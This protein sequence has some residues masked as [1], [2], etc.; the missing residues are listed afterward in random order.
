M[1][2]H[3]TF[4][5]ISIAGLHINAI[6]KID[7]LAQL[8]TRIQSRQK[9]FVVT[10][11][12]EF[13]YASMRQPEVRQLL[14]S[15]DFAIPDGVGI[16]W[17]HLFLNQPLTWNY[18]YALII[19]A[20]LQVVWTGASILL[21]PSLV[22]KDIPEKIVGADFIWDLSK[23]AA[24][25]NFSVYLLGGWGKTTDIVAKKLQS[26]FPRLQIVGTSTKNPDDKSIIDDINAARPDMVFVAL[27]AITQ[28]QWIA[29]NLSKITASFAIGLGGTF[30]YIAG[31]K[32]QP[33][34][35]VR[36]SGLEWLYRLIT[37]PTRISRIFNA[38]FGLVT[39][40]VR[41][42]VYESLDYRPNG[43]AVV[44]NKDGKILLC[45]R[46][47][48]IEKTQPG[49]TFDNYW[50]FPQGG[51]DIGESIVEGTKRELMEETQITSIE[52]LA[53]A[54]Y[55]NMY[56]WNNAMRPLNTAKR[57]RFK[58]QSQ[59]TVFFTFTGDDSEIILDEREL[60]DWKWVH[61]KDVIKTI[62]PERREHAEA[63]LAELAQLTKL[64]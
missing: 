18:F 14:N 7:L 41:Y 63:V 13:L 2:Q 49:R 11:Y 56:S 62:A 20:W 10:P 50:Q 57:Y 37:Q 5:K 47:P 42:K 4:K 31:T 25:N 58:G 39:S 43:S 55:V 12:S 23:L 51:L 6:T 44:I 9:T 3:N 26:K 38:T 33:P 59:S 19:Q 64:A 54:K 35:F 16:L 30:D 27:G 40:L 1:E 34:Q 46:S 60:I 29:N 15:A 22:Y 45:L 52:V 61:V 28:E 48:N 53:Q 17:A 8:R 24:D 21:R 32:K 36:A